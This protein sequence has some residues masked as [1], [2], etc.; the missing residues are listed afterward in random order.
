MQ[1]MV[2]IKNKL[3]KYVLNDGQGVIDVAN[4]LFK[5][6]LLYETSEVYA[7]IIDKWS[8]MS[9]VETMLHSIFLNI[10]MFIFFLSFILYYSLVKSVSQCNIMDNSIGCR[11]EN[12]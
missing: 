10:T 11:R 1:V 4:E 12:L 2:Q 8:A 5:S 3:E 9:M 7:T 6:S